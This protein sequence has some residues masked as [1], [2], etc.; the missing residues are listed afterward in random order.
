MPET[1]LIMSGSNVIVLIL[2]IAIM[3]CITALI[4]CWLIETCSEKH[5]LKVKLQK[6]KLEEEEERKAAEI[7]DKWEKAQKQK[8]TK[9]KKRK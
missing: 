7:I 8:S 1:Y 3:A 4:S 6:Y 5:D 2:C 9:G